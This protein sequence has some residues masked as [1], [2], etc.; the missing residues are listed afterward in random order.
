MGRDA[1]RIADEVVADLSGLIGAKVTVTLLVEAEI[2]SG[3]PDHVVRTVTENSRTLKITSHGFEK[4][5]QR[6]RVPFSAG[7]CGLALSRPIK[8]T[9]TLPTPRPQVVPSGTSGGRR[10]SD[11]PA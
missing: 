7:H 3:V 8:L 10:R 2:P 4:E 5:Q 6:D 9:L 11:P 1:S